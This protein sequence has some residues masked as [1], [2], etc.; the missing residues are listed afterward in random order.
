MN[1]NMLALLLVSVLAV[2]GCQSVKKELGVGRNSPDEFTVVKRAPLTM[3][4]E[5]DLR[6]PTD[7]ALP[8]GTNA[9]DAAKESLMGATAPASVGKGSAESALLSKM[10]TGAADPDIRSTLARENGNLAIESQTVKDKLIGWGDKPSEDKIPTPVVDPKKEAARLKKN[11]AE[12]KPVTDGD[13]PVIEP[14]K[15]TIDKIF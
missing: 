13:V 4:P 11:K 6:P 15:G 2:S 14:K 3:P 9:S 10:G 12:G 7:G 8:S 5:Y 1:K